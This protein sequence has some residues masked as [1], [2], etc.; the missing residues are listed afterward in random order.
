MEQ[1]RQVTIYTD[2]A[3]VGNPGPG[4]YG[5]VLIFDDNRRELSGGFRLTTNNRME[6]LA[7]I[8]G[9]EALKEPCR[10]TLYS[11]SRYVV[12]GMSKGWAEKWRKNGWR[13]NKKERAINPDMWGRLLDLCARHEV[14]F[15][16][17]RGHAGIPENERCDRLAVAA[18]LQD[19]L[20]ADQ[21]YQ[22]V[23][24]ATRLV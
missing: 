7:A 2:G 18:S 15:R 20:P 14:E 16:W 22:A 4:G 24:P 19:N 1:K 11:D 8:E 21:G 6:L 10:V 9:L 12:D 3:C 5:T 23:P 13:R 17:V